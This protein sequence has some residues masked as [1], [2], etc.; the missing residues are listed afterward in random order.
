VSFP[1]VNA[2]ASRHLAHAKTTAGLSGFLKNN[3]IFL[4]AWQEIVGFS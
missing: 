2:E 1:V 3:T 4:P